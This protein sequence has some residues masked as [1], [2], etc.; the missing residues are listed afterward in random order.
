MRLFLPTTNDQRGKALRLAS[1]VILV[2]PLFDG[3]HQRIGVPIGRLIVFHITRI[4]VPD[5]HE[6]LLIFCC[7]GNQA[8]RGT[9]GEIPH[10]LEQALGFLTPE[11]PI[12]LRQ[13]QDGLIS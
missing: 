2:R 4:D 6:P 12:P 8:Q 13:L 5:H 7:R 11:K 3:G 9:G 10:L 1:L